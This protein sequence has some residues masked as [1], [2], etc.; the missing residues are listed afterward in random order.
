MENQ[1]TL[2]I[3]EDEPELQKLIA[4]G[5]DS[6]GVK[7]YFA[8]NGKEALKV[9]KN[10][11][12][13]AILSDIKMP[14]MTGIELLKHIRSSDMEIPFVILTGHGDKASAVEALRLGALDFLDKP[15]EEEALVS[16][17]SK[18][19]ELGFQSRLLEK[20]IQD[21][22]ASSQI[23][24]DRID[25]FRKAKRAVIQLRIQNESA[26]KNKAG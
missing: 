25:Y 15:F 26:Q 7:I 14:Q 12:I 16:V 20:E 24:A 5:L 3:V 10:N 19:V 21:L 9:I 1:K 8:N 6:L 22:C 11:T 4:M 2:L 23:P 13:D 17:M 18:A